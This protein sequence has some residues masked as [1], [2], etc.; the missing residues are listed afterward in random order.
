MSGDA[1]A[2]AGRLHPDSMPYTF[3]SGDFKL[4]AK[5]SMVVDWNDNVRL[6][7]Q[8]PQQDVILKP[9]LGLKASYPVSERNL[10]QLDM[11]FGYNDY[12][13][14]NDLSGWYVQSGSALMFDIFVKDFKINL[15]DR[16]SYIQDS[17]QEAAVANTGSY[18]SLQNLV[19]INTTWDLRDVVLS[20]G[21]DHQNVL[22]TSQQFQQIDRAAEML[23]ARAGL[24]L[25]PRLTTGIEGA[26]ALTS[27]NQRQLNDGVLYS[28]GAYADWQVGSALRVQPRVGYT[29]STFRQTS[30]VIPAENQASWYADLTA[31]HQVT[32]VLG[33]SLSAGHEIR[34]GIQADS[35]T[36]YYIRPN[37][38]WA[39]L[40]HVGVNLFL[41]YERGDQSS[42]GLLGNTP[43]AY[44]YLGTGFALN[45]APVKKI[46]MSLNYRGTLRSSNL[47]SRDYT[48]NIIGI[49]LIYQMQ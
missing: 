2:E 14:H 19:G 43:E 35:I 12:V 27:Y 11:T 30:L 21:Y 25:H 20:L 17:S 1:A 45:Y 26:T 33:Y 31:S 47:A 6:S 46:Q 23:V 18:G 32:D 41:S 49:M 13:Q 3:K 34:P 15:H 44:D 39:I 38:N 37:V 28:I 48:Q 36:D 8:S 40:K 5:P 29:I 10:L 4:L 9:M 7:E 16:F 42:G 24:R 22:S